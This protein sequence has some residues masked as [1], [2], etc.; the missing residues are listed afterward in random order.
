MRDRSI[1]REV[2]FIKKR[3]RKRKRNYLYLFLE[4]RNDRTR[5]ELIRKVP[6][7][8]ERFMMLVKVG[9]SADWHIGLGEM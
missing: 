2:F 1:V 5:F 7:A 3:K 6:E 4:K 8:R 9:R